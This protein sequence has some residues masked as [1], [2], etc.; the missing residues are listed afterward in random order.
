MERKILHLDLDAFFCAVEELRDPSLRGKPFAVGGRPEQRGVIAACSYAARR[1]GIHSAMPTATALRLCPHLIL[2]SHHRG[3]YSEMSRQVMQRLHD[4]TPLVEQL[5]ID[6]AFADVSFLP[7]DPATIARTLQASI[8]EELNLPCSIGVATNKLVAKIANNVGKAKARG[9]SP[10]NAIT[11]VPPG[12]EAAFLSPLP[13]G[14]LWGVGPKTA[15]ALARHGVKT[16]GDVT[17]W[18]PERLSRLFGKNGEAIARHARGI[19]DRPV[20][21]ER[22][23]K[24][25]S[26]E[27][28][29]ARNVSDATLLE[30]TLRQLSD[31]VGRQVRQSGLSGTTVKIKLRW[32]DFTTLTRQVTLDRPI[33][34]DDAIFEAAVDLFRRVWP[35]GK[36]VRLIGVGLSGFA[37]PARQL[38]LFEDPSTADEKRRLQQTLD[39]LRERYGD[40]A[41]RR[42]SDLSLDDL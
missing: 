21:P 37:A 6:E 27:V 1:F 16:I 2:I 24:S 13:I 11:V 23:T 18:P 19:D 30:R 10:P 3:Q 29:F 33:D 31:G 17:A 26:K 7:D 41:V 39:A 28:T 4:L 25:I 15:E 35:V 38:G 8:N 36:P 20:E 14:E 32:A 12:Q 40:D 42:M 9:D 5:S 34:Q 22:E